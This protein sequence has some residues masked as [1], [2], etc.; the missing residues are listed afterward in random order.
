MDQ[1]ALVLVES[2]DEGKRAR[3]QQ[4][5]EANLRM[6]PNSKTVI[7]TAAWVQFRLGSVDVADRMLGE[8][9][10]KV[11]LSPQSAYYVAQLLKSKGKEA[12]AKSVLEATVKSP[13]IFVQRA[14]V[15]EELGK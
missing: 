11:A 13:G 7:A 3:A 10:S 15:K 5:S 8:L 14:K 12:D 9:A 1:L 6:T 2:G 4:L